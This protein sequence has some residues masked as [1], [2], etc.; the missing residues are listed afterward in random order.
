[1]KPLSISLVYAVCLLGQPRDLRLPAESSGIDGIAQALVSAFDQ[2]DIVALGEAHQRKL[3]S[4]LRIAMVR[5]PAFAKMVRTIVVEFGSTTEQPTLDRY[6]RGEE[7]P[8]AELSRVWTTTTQAANGIWD[9]PIYAEFL[10]AVRDGNAKLP[11]DLQI[12]VLGGDP[13]PGDKRSREAAA[14]AVL[15]EEV[16]QRRGK[17]LVIYGSAHFYRAYPDSYLESSGEDVGLARMLERHFPGRTLTVIPIGDLARPP[18]AKQDAEPD[19]RKFDIALETA[20]RP[21]LVSLQRLPF[22]N[23]T[24]EEFLGRTLTTCRGPGGCKSVFAWSTLTLG[25]MAD[26]CVYLG[27]GEH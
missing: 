19:Y 13:G 12:R 22:R 1:M 23:L 6:I 5:H 10:K 2:A 15:R 14:F 3:D 24:A 26:A 20:I 27:K 7:V 25:E 9:A 8:A 17:A 16:L 4:E 21:V 18:A 11:A